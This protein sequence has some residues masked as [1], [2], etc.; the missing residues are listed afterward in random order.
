V[1]AAYIYNLTHF[2]LYIFKVSAFELYE[3]YN[4]V[5][6]VSALGNRT[7]GFK[8]L[9]FNGGLS[10]REAYRSSYVNAAVF[11]NLTAEFYRGGIYRNH[12]KAVAV[13][14]LTEFL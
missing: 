3:V 6:F 10:E 1:L 11:K 13:A 4:I 12:G 7:L 8:N 14:F 2:I 9:V 5:D